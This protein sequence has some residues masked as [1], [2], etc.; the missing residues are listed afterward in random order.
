MVSAAS[1][2]AAVVLPTVAG[3]PRTRAMRTRTLR[4]GAMADGNASA[5]TANKTSVAAQVVGAVLKFPPFWEAASKNAKNMMIKRA[6]EL[7]IDWDK[8]VMTLQARK[9]R[10]GVD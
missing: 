5:S 10:R 8:E 6:G 7:D 1:A 4:C 3:P 2:A 9:D